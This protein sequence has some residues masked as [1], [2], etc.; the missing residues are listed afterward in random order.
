MPP[1]VYFVLLWTLECCPGCASVLT[2]LPG[3]AWVIFMR[4]TH[5]K[6]QPQIS[7]KTE[8]GHSIN[9]LL[10]SL[11][12]SKMTDVFYFLLSNKYYIVYD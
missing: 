12:Y 8:K 9:F 3:L 10:A 11:H 1:V 7:D 6:I 5:H 2:V 4:R